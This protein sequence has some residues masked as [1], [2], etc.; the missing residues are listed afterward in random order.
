MNELFTEIMVWKRIDACSAV[1]YSC[2]SDLESGKFAVQSADFFRVPLTRNSTNDFMAQFAELF[3]ETSPRERCI[4]FDSLADAIFHH[5][6]VF[7]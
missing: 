2:V 3:I 1:R 4:W 6:E 7:S 5:D